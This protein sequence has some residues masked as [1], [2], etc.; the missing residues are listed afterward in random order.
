[1][2][3]LNFSP[4]TVTLCYRTFIESILL[5][6][7][8]HLSILFSHLKSCE[9][10]ELE[11]V[12]ASTNKIRKLDLPSTP[13][14]HNGSGLHYSDALFDTDNPVITFIIMFNNLPSGK[15]HVNCEVD[16]I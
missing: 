15:L 13:Q 3:V 16:L 2:E 4:R 5:N 6:L 7:L 12:V 8:K 1:M 14:K 10:A 11:T 9:R